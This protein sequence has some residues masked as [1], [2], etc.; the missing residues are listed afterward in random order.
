MNFVTAILFLIHF[1]GGAQ[2]LHTTKQHLLAREKG[3]K[4]HKTAK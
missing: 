2:G 4:A 1:T 3:T